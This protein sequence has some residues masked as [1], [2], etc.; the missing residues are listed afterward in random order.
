MSAIASLSDAEVLNQL[1]DLENPINRIAD[2]IAIHEK[3]L[4]ET[5]YR[6]VLDWLSPVHFKDHHRGYS[7]NRLQGSGDWLLNHREF[8]EWKASSASSILLLHGTAG[9][10]KTYLASAVVD[11][12]AHDTMLQTTPAPFAYFYC[13]KSATENKRS[14]RTEI[15]R[16]ILRQL[17]VTDPKRKVV[18]SAIVAEFDRREIEAKIDGFDVQRLD[19]QECVRLTLDITSTIPATIIIDA[20]D[21]IPPMSRHELVDALRKITQ[22]SGSVVK[23]FITSRDESQISALLSMASKLR[24]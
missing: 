1:R 2:Q 12:F 14:D 18:H 16:S 6:E 24:I 7:K 8:L 4:E 21:E 10:G 13:A 3:T 17:S 9:S 22:E 23:V 15:L 11:S 20:V 19:V 5:R